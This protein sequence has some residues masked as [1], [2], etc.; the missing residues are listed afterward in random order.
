MKKII[1]WLLTIVIVLSSQNFVLAQDGDNVWKEFYVSAVGNDT[2]NGLTKEAPFRTLEKARDSIREISG[3]MQGDIIVN[4]LGE[5]GILY[6]DKPFRLYTEDSAQNGYRIVYRGVPAN[7]KELA[8]VSAGIP[9]TGWKPSENHPG[10]W[11]TKIEDEDITHIRQLYVNN[12]KSFMAQNDAEVTGL[13][14]YKKS[15]SPYTSDGMYISK[16]IMGEYENPDDVEFWWTRNWKHISCAVEDIYADPF[17]DSRLIVEMQQNW[18]SVRSALDESSLS[19]KPEVPFRILNAFELL[20]IPGEHYFNEK[21]RVLYYMPREDEDMLTA[22]VIAPKQDKILKMKGNDIDEKIKNISF[23]NLMLAHVAFNAP[24]YGGL[25]IGQ[26]TL[27]EIHHG[28][29]SVTQGAIHL[30]MTDGITFRNNYFFGYGTV[31][32]DAYNANDN[33]TVVGNAFSDFAET[34]FVAGSDQHNDEFFPNG[35]TPLAPEPAPSELNLIS[36][37]VRMWTSNYGKETGTV[38]GMQAIAGN[39]AKSWVDEFVYTGFWTGSPSAKEDGITNFVKYDF[40]DEYTISEIRL[41]FDSSLV[42]PEA[43]SNYE[44]LLSNDFQFREGNYTVVATQTE[45]AGDWAVYKPED[46]T[47]YRYMMI[48]SLE[49]GHPLSLSG[50]YAMTPDREPYTALQRCKNF[51]IENNYFRRISDTHYGGAGV[52]YFYLEDAKF[53]HNEVIDNPYSGFSMGWGWW[54]QPTGSRDVELAYNYFENT[55]LAIHDGGALYVLGFHPNSTIHDNY[56]Y[57]DVGGN[58]TFYLDMGMNYSEWYKNV[59]VYNNKYVLANVEGAENSIHDFYSTD[60]NVTTSE[61]TTHPKNTKLISYSN[62]PAE[63]KKIMDN[64]GLEPEYEHIKDWVYEE[65]I[66]LP[67]EEYRLK[68]TYEFG[69]LADTLL[70]STVTAADTVLA[71]NRFGDMLGQFPLHYKYEL[72]AMKKEAEEAS[73]KGK[74]IFGHKAQQLRLLLIDMDKNFKRTNLA[75]LIKLG[76]EF[77][78]EAK[79]APKSGFGSYPTDEVSVFETKLAYARNQQQSGL[80]PEQEYSLLQSLENACA[81]L[82]NSER[83]GDIKYVTADDMITCE[84]DEATNTVTMIFPYGTDL[85]VARTLEFEL[86]E[87]CVVALENLDRTLTEPLEVP[88]YNKELKQNEV[89]TVVGQLGQK[90]TNWYNKSD[91]INSVLQRENGVYLA[92]R[93]HPHMEAPVIAGETKTVVLEPTGTADKTNISLIMAAGSKIDMDIYSNRSYFDRYEFNMNEDTATLSVV[94]S[95]VKKT[96]K[97]DIK[98]SPLRVNEKNE[99]SYQIKEE[100]GRVRM[101]IW[102]DGKQV[103]N[104]VL[105]ES[106]TDGYFGIWSENQGILV[107]GAKLVEETDTTYELTSFDDVSKNRWSAQAITKLAEKGIV[108]GTTEKT[109][110]PTRNITRDEFLTLLVKGFD[111]GLETDIQ[112]SFADVKAGLWNEPYITKAVEL[113][114]VKGVSET[115]FG[116]G[117]EITRQDMAVMADNMLKALTLVPDT[118]SVPVEFSDGEG[119]AGYAKEAVKLLSEKGILN[120]NEKGE[121]M[122]LAYATREQ[123]AKVIYDLLIKLGRV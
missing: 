119:V 116:V 25:E 59:A 91:T 3:D 105:D 24:A 110:E 31:G 92:P 66:R 13:G 51:R 45:P 9:V 78:K 104:T 55:S 65:Q 95:G 87:N 109:F 18:W 60:N 46:D 72:Q 56:A 69:T 113:G 117:K 27:G 16:E 52:N 90:G 122:P 112:N 75:E 50:V 6:L 64:S 76:E 63:A 54:R 48:R 85:G 32:L 14:Y 114:I 33:L 102:Q 123:A 100:N 74:L 19:M 15:G 47:K 20:D 84:I 41:G 86:S 5:G 53:L 93:F 17:D 30:N 94:N 120:G 68:R 82:L 35:T 28:V 40:D 22:E 96:L 61:I 12:R 26:S 57:N 111:I 103:L 81:D 10:L 58:G 7:G 106:R 44:V 83:Q 42:T 1:T 77:L 49:V 34:A 118:V 121:F 70:S 73:D 62:P 43:K 2:N 107:H 67:Q 71:E 99:F 4:I 97:S 8:V 23:E 115:E 11:E 80:S 38:G 79:A 29:T 108:S 89:W 39:R 88:V 37:Y 36:G 98:V 21:T 101:I